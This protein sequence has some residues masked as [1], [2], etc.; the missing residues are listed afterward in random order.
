MSLAN[1]PVLV[2][3]AAWGVLEADSS[4]LR[5]FSIDTVQFMTTAAAIIGAGIKFRTEEHPDAAALAA[6]IARAQTRGVLL[7]EMQHRVKNNFQVI[8]SAISI[9]QRRFRNT[10]VEHALNHVASRI[11]A[12]SL[13]HD[14]LATRDDARV[15]DMANYLR[16]LCAS[17]QQQ[18]ENIAIDIEA[19]D[20]ELPIDRAVSV[21]LL[22]NELITNSIKHAFSQSGGRVL[23][24]LTTGIGYGEA[25]LVIADDGH[26][27]QTPRPGGTGLRLV[28]ALARQIGGVLDQE[29]SSSGTRTS[30]VFPVM[31]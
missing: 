5:D 30:L 23:V 25:R 19:A 15:V 14:Q 20:V 11:N 7:R 17:L 22:V 2:N 9:Q 18:T 27:I 28:E 4:E 12:I 6:E 29:S 26:G 3:G 1:V 24:Q 21:G 16:V 13:A 8:L 10:E 31:S